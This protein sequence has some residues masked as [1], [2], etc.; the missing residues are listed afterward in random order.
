MAGGTWERAT[1]KTMLPHGGETG[2]ASCSSPSPRQ[3]C[4]RRARAQGQAGGER[5]A[6]RV[7]SRLACYHRPSSSKTQP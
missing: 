3:A 4:L 1:W 6:H 5:G 2:G 7:H